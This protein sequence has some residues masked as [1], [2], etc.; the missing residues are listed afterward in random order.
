MSKAAVLYVAPGPVDRSH[1]AAKRHGDEAAYDRFKCRCADAREDR[2]L[3][4]KRRREGRNPPGRVPAIGARRRITA[5]LAIGW[6]A[7]ALHAT[8]GVALGQVERLRKAN[9]RQWVQRVTHDEWVKVYAQLSMIPGP[10]PR[11][12]TWARKLGY[13]PPLLWEGVDM[14]DPDA[15]PLVD[16]APPTR[17]GRQPVDRDELRHLLV[18]GG[19]TDPEIC[20]VFGITANTLEDMLTE[21]GMRR[22][23]AV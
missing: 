21:L 2:R 8:A 23:V 3:R 16:I 7:P 22:K 13:A 6:S 1:C 9:A 18:V 4:A 12:I 19:R 10:S 11:A 20:K 17:A 15:Q 5:L 14:D